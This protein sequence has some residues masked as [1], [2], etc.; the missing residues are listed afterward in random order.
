MSVGA[1]KLT[2]VWR[3][4]QHKIQRFLRYENT[5]FYAVWIYSAWFLAS[6]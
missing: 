2:E 1:Q 4:E 3:A 6:L 5:G